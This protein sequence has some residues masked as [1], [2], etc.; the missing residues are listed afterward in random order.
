VGSSIVVS[1]AGVSS[2][3][4]TFTVA[5]NT[6]DAYNPILTW[7]QTAANASTSTY[8]GTPANPQITFYPMAFITGT[9]NGVQGVAQLGTNSV[10]WTSGDSVVSAP[11]SEVGIKGNW[12]VVGQQTPDDG[13]IGSQALY[14]LD[15]G[16]APPEE[17]IRIRNPRA[18]GVTTMWLLFSPLLREVTITTSI[19]T[20]DGQQR[21]YVLHDRE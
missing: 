20:I 14:L 9:N 21:L 6:L 19:S 1:G 13:T 15:T 17:T 7:A 3:N 5:S 2:F 18:D 10:V 4:G 12:I 11:S 16:P 8:N